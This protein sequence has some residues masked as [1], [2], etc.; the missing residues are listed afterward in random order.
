MW[1]NMV[2]LIVILIVILA[3]IVYFTLPG[4]RLQKQ[5]LADIKRSFAEITTQENPQ[6][7]FTEDSIAE[8][9]AL[10]RQHIINGG[11]LNHLFMDNMLIHFYN[12]KFRTSAG[13]KP[14]NIEFIQV[15]FA[16]R[17]DRHAFLN[18]KIVGM[19][20]QAKDSVLDGH[21]SMT[22]MLG[23]LFQLFHVT[24]VEMDQSQLIT[25]LADAVYMPSFF[26]QDFITWRVLDDHRVEFEIVW[27][28]VSA[29]GK[30]T[31]DDKGN[32]IQFDTNDR[33]MDNNNKG[34]SLV[35]WYVTY[36]N[37]KEQNGY[38]QPGSV[39]VNWVLPDGVDTYFTSNNIEIHY[40]INE[41]D[42]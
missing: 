41:E 24:G 22:V 42:L 28:D 21:G 35:P 23:K 38:F 27:K 17:P 19:P 15:N 26:L 7:V 2:W 31:F 37:Y 29:K 14:I 36:S 30:F 3:T 5:Y 1:T 16:K 13:K 34:S 9:P 25:T 6:N 8:L 32:I 33:Y 11:Y 20:I 12:S 39:S 10:L 4:G 40:S 18:G